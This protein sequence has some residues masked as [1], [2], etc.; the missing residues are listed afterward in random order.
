MENA[1][2][3]DAVVE[4]AAK[5]FYFSSLSEQASFAAALKALA[6]LKTNGWLG[7]EH[8]SKWIQILSK[9]RI[10][11]RSLKSKAWIAS[12]KDAG[13]V[14]PPELD[15]NVWMTFLGNGE[16]TEVEAV[17]L[18]KILGFSDEDIAAG[19]QVTVGTVRY[20]I[21]RGLRHL[22]GYLES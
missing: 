10:R 13:F 14:L 12:A 20:R 18:S 19:L 6:D 22:G 15:I 17:L 2:A 16:P 7:V 3:T 1:P 4:T 21:G 9:W 11:L 8:K 5:Y